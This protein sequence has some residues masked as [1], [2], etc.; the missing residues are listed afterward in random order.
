MI[1]SLSSSSLT[2]TSLGFHK[3]GGRGKAF[4]CAVDSGW[5]VTSDL[6]GKDGLVCEWRVLYHGGL[7]RQEWGKGIP[8]KSLCIL[9]DH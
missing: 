7:D 9:G 3:E 8:V 2:L 4:C 6:P 5:T 1:M